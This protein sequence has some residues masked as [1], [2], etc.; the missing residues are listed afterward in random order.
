MKSLDLP[1]GSIV[2][3]HG[4][5]PDGV[6]S[7]KRGIMGIFDRLD[8]LL[9]VVRRDEMF[10]FESL[11]ELKSPVTVRSLSNVELDIY[12]VDE[13]RSSLDVEKK[14]AVLRNIAKVVNTIRRRYPLPSEVRMRDIIKELLNAGVQ[15]D[16]VE[17]LPLSLSVNDSLA[18][19]KVIPEFNL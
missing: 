11:K 14:A 1:P 13:F 17:N 12:E 7:V 10:G 9:A 3:V 15:K 4:R 16:I 8:R 5:V 19:N 18:F 6:Y 2:V